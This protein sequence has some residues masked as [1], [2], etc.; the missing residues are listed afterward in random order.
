MGGTCDYTWSMETDQVLQKYGCGTPLVELPNTPPLSASSPEI[1]SSSSEDDVYFDAIDTLPPPISQ[2]VTPLPPPPTTKLISPSPL[3]GTVSI[4]RS[5]FYGN[6]S[7]W[8]ADFLHSLMD[9]TKQQPPIV[10]PNQDTNPS[11]IIVNPPITTMTLSSTTNAVVQ[12]VIIT[13]QQLELLLKRFV[14]HLARISFGPNRGVVYWVL[15]YVFIR[16]PVEMLVKRS[17]MKVGT[18]RLTTTTIGITAA[19]A[20]AMSAGLSNAL[21][22]FK[23]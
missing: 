3:P 1:C 21:E 9:S 13:G 7:S 10:L 11:L 19:I 2:P 12:R 20:A 8:G 23:K 22:K 16:V 4:S 6:S 18:K 14:R 5:F 15:L 17:L